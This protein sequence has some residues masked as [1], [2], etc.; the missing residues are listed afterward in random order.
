MSK[1]KIQKLDDTNNWVSITGGK[2]SEK[3]HKAL[4]MFHSIAYEHY[5]TSLRLIDLHKDNVIVV[6]MAGSYRSQSVPLN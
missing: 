2:L 4:R 3:K 1:F 6:K 5:N